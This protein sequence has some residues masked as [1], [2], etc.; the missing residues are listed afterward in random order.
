MAFS[1]ATF[2]AYTIRALLLDK[3]SWN[4]SWDILRFRIVICN[5]LGERVIK[6]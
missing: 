1:H 2:E 6:H 4:L 3:F 5:G